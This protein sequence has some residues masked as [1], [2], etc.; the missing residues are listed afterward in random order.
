MNDGQIPITAKSFRLVDVLGRA[1]SR[2]RTSN[3]PTRGATS[4][5]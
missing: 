4:E 1:T 2:S 3:V 5:N